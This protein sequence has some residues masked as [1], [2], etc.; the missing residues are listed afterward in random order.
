[1][2]KQSRRRVR[3]VKSRDKISMRRLAKVPIRR[4]ELLETRRPTGRLPSIRETVRSELI[5]D[6]AAYLADFDEVVAQ[7]ERHGLVRVPEVAEL[8]RL[9]RTS[10]VVSLARWQTGF[11]DQG[12]RGTCY[13]FAACAGMEAAYRRSHG[14]T[15]DLS[16]HFAFHINK[17]GELFPDHL[18]DSRQYENNSSYWGFQGNSGIV[19]KLARSAIPDEAA[20]PYLSQADMDALNGG[21]IPGTGSDAEDSTTQEELDALEFSERHIPTAARHRAKYRVE[22]Y[23]AL[24]R[25]PTVEQIQAVISAGYEVIAGVPGHV[26]L[27]VGFDRANKEWIIK[28]SWGEGRF[29]TTPFDDEDWPILGGHYIVSVAPPDAPVSKDAWWIGR[30]KMDHDGWRGELII[31]RTTDY[32]DDEGRPTKLGDYYRGGEKFAV[33]GLVEEDGRL[34]H[35]WIADRP[36]RVEPGSKTGQEFRVY[37]FSHD[38]THAAGV[39]SWSRRPFGVSLS[40]G[41][42]PGTRT[43]GFPPSTWI[44]RWSMNH[45]G[46]RGTLHITSVSPFRASY[47]PAGSETA[48]AVRGSVNAKEAHKLQF[49]IK[50]S[51]DNIQP[52]IVYGHTW[53][54][55]VFSGRT[56]WS[57]RTFGVKGH[58]DT[59]A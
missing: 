56:Q 16:E 2:T 26:L 19:S 3:A 48:L 1:M 15:L 22:E 7:A 12:A 36:G 25:N 28:N 51:P 18:T 39:T 21:V 27:I 43:E 50:F 40:R 45:D 29:I 23:A 55:D 33:N 38:P 46:W 54:R 30:W 5:E 6:R 9:T 32:R 58:R 20:A 47:T 42:Q 57:G 10:D 44:G 41:S 4:S 31:R 8:P 53:E 52:F 37:V 13:V 17:A 11:R 35:F 59:E 49:K 14:V 24:P 34:L